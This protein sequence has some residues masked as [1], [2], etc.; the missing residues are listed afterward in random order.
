MTVRRG[1]FAGGGTVHIP[2]NLGRNELTKF[3]FGMMQSEGRS[4]G[5]GCVVET[6]VL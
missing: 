2:P 6:D 5:E 1:D 3:M 4:C